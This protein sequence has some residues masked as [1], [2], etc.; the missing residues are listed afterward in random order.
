MYNQV[1]EEILDIFYDLIKKVIMEN[2]KC[3]RI[4]TGI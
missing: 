3:V 2:T 1:D 4:C